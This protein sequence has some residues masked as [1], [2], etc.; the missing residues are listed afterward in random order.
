MQIFEE[1][2]EIKHHAKEIPSDYEYSCTYPVIGE[3]MADSM[4]EKLIGLTHNNGQMTIKDAVFQLYE[5][6]TKRKELYR[7]KAKF[8]VKLKAKK[9]E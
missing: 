8:Y 1:L 4:A 3:H 2:P 9:D 5:D 7:Y 6:E